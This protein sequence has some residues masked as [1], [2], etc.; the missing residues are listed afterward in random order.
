MWKI[1]FEFSCVYRP[2]CIF[3]NPLTFFGA[4]IPLTIID[5]AVGPLTKSLSSHFAFD[6]FALILP[7]LNSTHKKSLPL[8]ETIDIL[9]LIEITI[10]PLPN[11]AAIREP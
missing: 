9:S 1:F 5:S 6:P 8:L 4:L 3:Q 2:I 10:F 7:S 11:A